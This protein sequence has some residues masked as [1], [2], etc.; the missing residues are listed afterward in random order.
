MNKYL[1]TGGAGFIGSPL[2]NHLAKEHNVVVI[3]NL[4]MGK[5]ENLETCENINFIKGDVSNQIKMKH[6]PLL[7]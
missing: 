2:A 3:D 6:T 4:S 5:K 1:I 7:K